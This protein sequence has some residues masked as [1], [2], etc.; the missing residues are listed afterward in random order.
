VPEVLMFLPGKTKNLQKLPPS[1]KMTT[2]IVKVKAPSRARQH[3]LIPPHSPVSDSLI[4]RIYRGSHRTYWAHS[5]K[6]YL[7]KLWP[8]YVSLLF[9]LLFHSIS[10]EKNEMKNHNIN[11]KCQSSNVKSMSN[12]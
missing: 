5:R 3:C 2:L 10:E 8:R 4:I 1:H 12:D 6:N 7:T 9:C 11:V